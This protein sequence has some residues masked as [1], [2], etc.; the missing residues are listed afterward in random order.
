MYH[1]CGYAQAMEA[2][3]L[4]VVRESQTNSYYKKIYPNWLNRNVENYNSEAAAFNAG[5]HFFIEYGLSSTV[6]DASDTQKRKAEERGNNAIE[7]YK[8]M[9]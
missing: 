1:P 4:M 5:Y 3:C 6:E 9:H 2:E 8:A 7:I